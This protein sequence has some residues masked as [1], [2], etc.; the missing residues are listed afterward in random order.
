MATISR[1]H[2]SA[3]GVVNVDTGSI[4]ATGLGKHPTAY[5]ITLAATGNVDVGQN[6]E[7]TIRSLQAA[8][9]VVMYQVD[10]VQL[11]VLTEAQGFGSDANVSAALGALATAVSSVNGFKLA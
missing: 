5:N 10:G 6:V 11:S 9:T 3:K 2:G 8:A 7:S 4:V 1:V